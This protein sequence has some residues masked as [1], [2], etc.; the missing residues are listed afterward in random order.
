MQRRHRSRPSAPR[1]A[2]LL[3]CLLVVASIVNLP[4]AARAEQPAAAF[5]AEQIK[6]FETEI[7]PLLSARCVKCHGPDKQQGGLRLDSRAAILAGGDMGAAATPGNVDESLLLEVVG[8]RGDIKMPPTG[9]LGDRE[10]ALLQRWVTAGL[11]WPAEEST[12]TSHTAAAAE[13]PIPWSFQPVTDPALPDVQRAE[14]CRSPLDRFVLARLESAGL[15]PAPA[16]D[17]RTLLRR[18]KFDL[19]GLPPTPVEVDA[20]LADERPTAFAEL[21]ERFLA[22]PEY[23][24]RWARHWL[25]VA[26]YA[27]SNGQDE[28]LAYVNAFRYR[29]YVVDA[30]NGDKPY[31]QFVREQIAGDLLPAASDA[32]RFAHLVATGFLTLGPKMLAEDDPVKMQMDIVDEQLDALGGAFLGMT[33]GCARC[34]D[35]KFDPVSTS[36][37]YALAGIFKST[38]TMDNFKV[39]AKWHERPLASAEQIMAVEAHQASLAAKK[40]ELATHVEQAN[41]ALVAVARARLVDYLRT[42]TELLETPVLSSLVSSA[43]QRMRANLPAQ[44]IVREAEA[45]DRGNVLIDTTNYGTEIGVILNRAELPNFVEYDVAI[46][47]AGN[48]QIEVRYAAAEARSVTLSIG[49]QVRKQAVAGAVTGSWHPDTQRWFPEGVFALPAGRVVLRL[50]R[51][52]G[53]FPHF[54]CLA[55]VPRPDA[56][57]AGRTASAEELAH[58][59]GLVLGFLNQWTAYLTA[60]RA[61]PQSIWQPWFARHDNTGATPPRFE[62]LAA[63]V[64]SRIATPP[65]GDDVALA[66]CYRDLIEAADKQRAG[67]AAGEALA[68][69]DAALSAVV[70]DKKGP[71]RIIEKPQELYATADRDQFIRLERDV[72]ELEKSA[73]A[74]L[75]QAM[76]VAEGQPT[77]LRIHIRGS[78]LALGESSPRGF[79]RAL[80]PEG[81]ALPGDASGR[82]ELAQW[83]TAPQHPLTSRV[84][85]NRLWRWH[86]GAG[87]VRST[88]NF[89]NLGERPSH[90]ELLD[91][92]ARRFVDSGWSIKAMHRL[93]ML[94]ATYQMST[95]HNAAAVE[96]DPDNRLLWRMNRR[97]LEAEAV[98]DS[99]LFVAG[100]L[101]TSRSG[102]L[103]RSKPREYVTST[104]SVDATNYA[105]TRRSLY[106][107][108]VRSALYEPFQAFDFAEPTTIKGDRDNTTVASQALFMMNSEVMNEQSWQLAR[109]VITEQTDP[110][111]RIRALFALA[112]GRAP[113]DT[114]IPRLLDFI[115]RY[116]RV[117][118]EGDQAGETVAWQALCRVILSSNEFLYIE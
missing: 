109:R 59:H 3:Y 22:M 37:Y 31:D 45:F 43:E 70:T 13:R 35:H 51:S 114:E 21:I 72:S 76:A 61:N 71:L 94:S 23:G 41:R 117:P 32:E 46:P 87:I 67:L 95:A 44:T 48:Y 100:Q 99:L 97:R 15:P 19:L 1:I 55:L 118:T 112:L 92:L 90:P 82:L 7:R 26:R 110:A 49:G 78:H 50:E 103:L 28:N 5:S 98:R 27:D 56:P 39:V 65:P 60:E 62:G 9:K 33:L 25:D 89:G 18:A 52:G 74:E 113:R 86:F 29:D 11:P 16:A 101:D 47:A 85:M 64:A 96:M 17:K 53:P 20:F 115:D 10:I 63:A 38:Q 66:A 104:A 77:D 102:S 105:T 80:A 40:K 34:H 36:D 54:D 4:R 24:Q 6:F 106:L 83:I 68:D 14:W 91:W 88:D 93:I 107:P 42:A 79:P 111:A 69:V 2:R 108:V 30:F 58:E 73:P 116:P 84:M 12:P 57:E 81:A 75:P 8:Y